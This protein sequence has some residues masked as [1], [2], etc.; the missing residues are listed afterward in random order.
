MD[1]SGCSLYSGS[2]RAIEQRRT[3]ASRENSGDIG[4]FPFDV[5]LE[6]SHHAPTTACRLT[7]VSRGF[8]IQLPHVEKASILITIAAAT[9]PISSL[10]FRA[11]WM[12]A[13]PVARSFSC[14]VVP[15][16]KLVDLLESSA[17][18]V[19]VDHT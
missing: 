19:C 3:L 16:P 18:A 8:V 10:F 11:S 12:L 6:L 7:F 13:I 4:E 14:A 2:H 15:E 1:C 9:S 5:Y 17:I